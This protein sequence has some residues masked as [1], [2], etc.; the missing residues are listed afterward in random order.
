MRQSPEQRKF[1][2]ARARAASLKPIA[3]KVLKRK[4]MFAD[5]YR[6]TVLRAVQA[7]GGGK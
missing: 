7:L 6:E 3:F 4:L 5:Q 2:K 1:L